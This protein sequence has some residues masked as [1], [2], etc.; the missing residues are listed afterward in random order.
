MT[1]TA[2]SSKYK[3]SSK[4]KEAVRSGNLKCISCKK[5]PL[6]IINYNPK[7]FLPGHITQSKLSQRSKHLATLKKAM[8]KPLP[9]TLEEEEKEEEIEKE[10]SGLRR[11]G[12]FLEA[13]E[14]SLKEQ[15]EVTEALNYF[16]EV[17]A[18]YKQ[19]R[20]VAKLDFGSDPI[21]PTPG[22][23]QTSDY[24]RSTPG[25]PFGPKTPTFYKNTAKQPPY[26][27][28][29]VHRMA[30]ETEFNYLDYAPNSIL[31]K[32]STVLFMQN[33]VKSSAIEVQ[34]M[35]ANNSLFISANF[36][37]YLEGLALELAKYGSLKAF[38]SAID[39][40][41]SL[42]SR[43][44]KKAHQ[45]RAEI[46]A[47]QLGKMGLNEQPRYYGYKWPNVSHGI[48]TA[49]ASNKIARLTVNCTDKG[50]KFNEWEVTTALP[51]STVFIMETNITRTDGFHAEQLFYA[52]LYKLSAAGLLTEFNPA[53]IG[54]VKIP[55]GSCKAVIGA[56][57]SDFEHIIVGTNIAGF[58]Y[59][60]SA[61]HVDIDDYETYKAPHITAFGN[62]QNF[63][64]DMPTSPK[65]SY[66]NDIDEE[67]SDGSIS[68]SE[69]ELDG[70]K[71][72]QT[73]LD[74]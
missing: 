41:N 64:T 27:G 70:D 25:T 74:T 28:G 37:P 6:R 73:L 43:G 48:L 46:Y 47:K 62:G 45:E 24:D 2:V 23:F 17:Y 40:T 19:Y 39:D 29:E 26:L 31:R 5:G 56:M 42:V 33:K 61:Q 20:S 49:L 21:V 44:M 55:C 10:E 7:A 14:V 32:I 16:N 38:F 72:L 35:W 18:S 22:L 12:S 30:G 3:T 54:G 11:L 50:D 57:E 36:K 67:G 9:A 51:A 8:K 66:L 13:R 15:A 68:G 34:A 52:V 65:H 58:L 71:S 59:G 53:F 1:A 63:C 4:F 60:A 69:N